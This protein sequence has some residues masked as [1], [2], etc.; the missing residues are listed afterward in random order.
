M[1]RAACTLWVYTVP[2]R[3]VL[4]YSR[5][6]EIV[7]VEDGLRNVQGCLDSVL[8]SEAEHR[9]SCNISTFYKELLHLF[10]EATRK[11]KLKN[12][13]YALTQS[14][15]Y[16]HCFYYDLFLCK[17]FSFWGGELRISASV[18][19]MS[20]SGPQSGRKW[21]KVFQWR[22]WLTFNPSIT[23]FP[24][25][26]WCH[27]PELHRYIIQPISEQCVYSLT[28]KEIKW[29]GLGLQTTFTCQLKPS[30]L[31]AKHSFLKRYWNATDVM[32]PNWRLTWFERAMLLIPEE[33]L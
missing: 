11:Q 29:I 9:S 2:G 22:F 8:L 19:P 27:L 6:G 24:K 28:K 33:A 17:C 3:N 12:L 30:E 21:T 10:G 4:V 5:R 7:Q 31:L 14:V 25:F 26:R 20:I 16:L 18:N 1:S 32:I 13:K 15:T 23:D